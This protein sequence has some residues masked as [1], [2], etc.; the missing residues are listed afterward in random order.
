M[1]VE[2]DPLELGFRRPFTVEVSQ[3]LRIRNPNTSPVAFKVK[4][5]APKQ[6]CVRPNSGRI[7]PGHDV[8]VSV[9]LQAMKQEPPSDA[10]CRDKFLVQSVAITGDKEF[11]NVAQIWDGV[12]KSQVQ[13]KKIRV[14]WLPPFGEETTSPVAATPIRPSTSSRAEETPAPFTSPSETRSSTVDTRDIKQE[15]DV[16]ENFQ[17]TVA[18]VAS[19]AQH[20]ASETYEQLKEQ[21]AKAQATIASL[22]NDA[23][24]GLRQRKA[25]VADAV[26]EQASNVQAT[27]QDLAQSA[28]QGTEGV[29]VQ[30]AAVLCLVSF[31][32]AYIFF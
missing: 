10:R 28:R 9:L 26:G 15:S 21:L 25:A 24:S 27:A 4:T 23:A 2:I 16:G 7:E 30:I 13:E 19:T 6:Y 11:T 1:S 17:S 8:E 22:Q 31:L 18:A 5:T 20:T 3:I 14:L 29:P 12:D 32:L